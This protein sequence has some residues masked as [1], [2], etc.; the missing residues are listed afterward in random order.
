[1]KIGRVLDEQYKVEILARFTSDSAG[2]LC[3][4]DLPLV[5]YGTRI[6]QNIVT[7]KDKANEVKRSVMA[8]M[9]RLASLF[10]QFQKI[11]PTLSD[12]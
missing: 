5:L 6:C 3:T 1:M 12:T 11:C 7:K 10:L 8:D 9:R 4:S 2:N